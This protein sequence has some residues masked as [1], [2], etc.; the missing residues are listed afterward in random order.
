MAYLL[1]AFK[2]CTL[3]S[4]KHI[5]EDGQQSCHSSRL[6]LYFL[7]RL[8]RGILTLGPKHTARPG[9]AFWEPAFFAWLQ[10]LDMTK[11]EAPIDATLL[12]GQSTNIPR[13]D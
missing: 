10:D 11:L 5:V 9:L 4:G 7:L 12:F 2:C 6:P 3:G 13:T 1:F 8:L